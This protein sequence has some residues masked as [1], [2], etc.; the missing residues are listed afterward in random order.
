MSVRGWLVVAGFAVAWILSY[1]LACWWFPLRR[2]FCCKGVGRHFTASR[3][4]HRRCRWCA[5][6]GGRVRAGRRVYDFLH[7]HRGR[8]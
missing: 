7:R 3:K 1:A 6:T 8:A 2:C 5:G 4:H